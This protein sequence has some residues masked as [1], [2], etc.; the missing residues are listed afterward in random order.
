MGRAILAVVISYVVMLVLAFLAFTCAF[1]AFGSD[2]VF[3][4]G[5]YEASTIWIA[6]AFVINIVDAIIGG[7]ICALIAKRGKAPFALAIVVI[8][9]GLLVAFGDTKKRQTNLGLIR[10][11]NT[12]KFEEIQKAY[13]PVW[14]PFALPLTAAAGVLIGSRFK[15]KS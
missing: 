5:T 6:V 4:A 8:V 7:F 1:V 2:V 3:R 10:E 9:L 11:P 15:R 12:P 14:V 13:W